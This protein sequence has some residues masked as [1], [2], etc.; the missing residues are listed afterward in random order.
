[1]KRIFILAILILFLKFRSNVEQYRY[2]RLCIHK[3]ESELSYGDISMDLNS[4]DL[5]PWSVKYFTASVF[6]ATNF[7]SALNANRYFFFRSSFNALL[8]FHLGKKSL[9]NASSALLIKLCSPLPTETKIKLTNFEQNLT[10]LRWGCKETNFYRYPTLARY[11][12]RY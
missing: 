6:T 11:I 2:W 9:L 12:G 10:Q 8:V 5:K 1:M 7:S 3:N 4:V